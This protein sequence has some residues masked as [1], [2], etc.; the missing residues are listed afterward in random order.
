[1]KQEVSTTP[2][3]S[4][5]RIV[6]PDA[7]IQSCRRIGKPAEIIQRRAEGAPCQG[8]VERRP[9]LLREQDQPL[10]QLMGLLQFAS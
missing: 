9:L 2:I 7:L 3:Q 6:D 4:R 5:D 10:R 8:A 1:M